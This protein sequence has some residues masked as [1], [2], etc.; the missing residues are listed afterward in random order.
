MLG[1]TPYSVTE[2]VPCCETRNH[3]AT[4]CAYS[5][6][7]AHA[8]MPFFFLQCKT[9]GTTKAPHCLFFNGLYQ[10]CRCPLKAWHP[11]QFNVFE[12]VLARGPARNFTRSQNQMGPVEM[13]QIKLVEHMSMAP[14][15]ANLNFPQL[16][17]ACKTCKHLNSTLWLGPWHS[18]N[19][20][21]WK[22]VQLVALS[23]RGLKTK[24]H[25]DPV[26]GYMWHLQWSNT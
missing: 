1:R 24:T 14:F 17:G 3:S 12:K 21:Y 4:S 2:N 16:Y 19:K 26:L 15:S 13:E 18:M 5:N 23:C 10:P 11:W 20:N 22:I 8:L 6:S 9:L 7:P 25:V